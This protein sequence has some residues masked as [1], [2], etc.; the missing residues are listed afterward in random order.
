MEPAA[1]EEPFEFST[2]SPPPEDPTIEMAMELARDI[3]LACH[4]PLAFN[5]RPG[6]DFSEYLERTGKR[7]WWKVRDARFGGDEYALNR[8]LRVEI[9]KLYDQQLLQFKRLAKIVGRR[10][11][12]SHR[13]HPHN[14]DELNAF[15]LKYCAVVVTKS[16]LG[17]YVFGSR[18][19]GEVLH[20]LD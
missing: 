6:W 7:Q 20:R 2:P 5:L 14:R 3:F 17:N 19:F 12:D 4:Q 9:N 1:T 16:E 8:F 11:F 15:T 13:R 10:F 18:F